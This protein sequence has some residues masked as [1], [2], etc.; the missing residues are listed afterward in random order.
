MIK[1]EEQKLK[2]K[3]SEIDKKISKIR[4]ETEIKIAEINNKIKLAE[5]EANQNIEMLENEIVVLKETAHAKAKRYSQQKMIDLNEKRLVP[6]KQLA[7]WLE[8]VKAAHKKVYSESILTYLKE[9]ETLIKEIK[10]KNK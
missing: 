9:S 6:E 10:N 1:K 5:K 2:E 3:E 7:N 4:A 8:N